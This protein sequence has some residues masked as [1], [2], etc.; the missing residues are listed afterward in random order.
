L[1]FVRYKCSA[2]RCAY[3]KKSRPGVRTFDVARQSRAPSA[4][5]PKIYDR[6]TPDALRRMHRIRRFED[7]A[8]DSCIP[9]THR[10]YGHRI[11]KGAELTPMFVEFLGREGGYCK[12]HGGSMH[13]ADPA[14]GNLGAHGI[15]GGGLPIAVGAA[16]SANKR[17]KRQVRVPHNIG[18]H[19]SVQVQW[20]S[21][22]SRRRRP[23]VQQTAGPGQWNWIWRR[24]ILKLGFGLRQR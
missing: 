1:H 24:E 16:L 17:R 11:A 14:R 9:S 20:S 19:R 6:L 21:L 23:H 4:N 22:R 7:E 13:I 15:G 18:A 10:G 12:G 8:E 5:R 3:P 2:P